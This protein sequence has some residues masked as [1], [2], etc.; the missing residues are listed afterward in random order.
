TLPAGDVVPKYVGDLHGGTRGRNKLTRY[1]RVYTD[2]RDAKVIINNLRQVT[3]EDDRNVEG[4]AHAVRAIADYHLLSEFGES[5]ESDQQLG[6][7][8]VRDFDMEER[9]LRATCGTTKTMIEQ[10]F[11]SALSY[12]VTDDIYRYTVDVVKAYQ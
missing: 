3:K 4:A 11:A 12:A 1:D 2:M 10:D 5:C 8:L 7:P 9:P 6:L